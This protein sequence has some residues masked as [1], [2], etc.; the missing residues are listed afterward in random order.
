MRTGIEAAVHQQWMV[1][2]RNPGTRRRDPS[3]LGD[4]ARAGQD[5][6]SHSGNYRAGEQI[7]RPDGFDHAGQVQRRV[8][9]LAIVSACAWP[10]AQQKAYVTR[11]VGLPLVSGWAWWTQH[12]LLSR[13]VPWRAILP[14]AAATE[15]GMVESRRRRCGDS[16]PARPSALGDRGRPTS[17]TV[18]GRGRRPKTSQTQQRRRV[19]VVRVIWGGGVVRRG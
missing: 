1:A 4:L 17:R 11:L 15:L 6:W 7:A 19:T 16:A 3:G 9:E 5:G 14:G 10:A 13:R 8:S 18:R 12:L 2:H